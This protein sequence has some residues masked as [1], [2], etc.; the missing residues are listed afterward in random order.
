MKMPLPKRSEQDEVSP[1]IYWLYSLLALLLLAPFAYALL[2]AVP[3]A[4]DFSRAVR[5]QGLFDVS[6]GLRETARTWLEHG[7]RYTHHFLVYSLGG[8]FVRPWGAPLLCTAPLVLYW[9]GFFGIFS[10]LS[11][12]GASGE[13]FFFATLALLRHFTFFADLP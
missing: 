12:R 10:T 3:E 6:G 13:A 7:G 8:V 9:A 2:H 1:Y 11:K 4:D 5:A